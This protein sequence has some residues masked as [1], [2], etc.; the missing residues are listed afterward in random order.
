MTNKELIKLLKRFPASASIVMV[1]PDGEELTPY[2]TAA[3][4]ESNHWLI[5]LRPVRTD[6]PSNAKEDD[7]N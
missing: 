3:L 1:S 6:V 4:T 5:Q 7:I 2:L